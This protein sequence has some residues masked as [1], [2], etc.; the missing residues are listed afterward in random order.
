MKKNKPNINN[1]SLLSYYKI[2]TNNCD[3]SCSPDIVTDESLLTVTIQIMVCM[4]LSFKKHICVSAST[5]EDRTKPHIILANQYSS[6]Q[7]QSRCL[8]YCIAYA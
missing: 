7:L 4:S 8:S 2:T 5:G 3:L 1:E 6:C